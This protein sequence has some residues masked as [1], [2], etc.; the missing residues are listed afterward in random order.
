MQL[1]INTYPGQ[2]LTTP[3][4]LITDY[5]SLGQLGYI[6]PSSLAYVLGKDSTGDRRIQSLVTKHVLKKGRVVY[7]SA[8]ILKTIQERLHKNILTQMVE[9]LP[10]NALACIAAYRPKLSIPKILADERYHGAKYLVAIDIKKYF[11]NITRK[12]IIAALTSSG[13]DA[14]GATLIAR[15]STVKRTVR[16]K[17]VYTLQQGSNAS[18]AISNLVGYW[19]MDRY[20]LHVVDSLMATN[21][22]LRIEYLRY[23]D[24]LNFWMDGDLGIEHVR[25]VINSVN[26]IVRAGHFHIH[27]PE[28]MP[29]NHPKRNQRVL[30]IVLN[31]TPRI[32]KDDFM[33][34]RNTLFNCCIHSGFQEVWRYFQSTSLPTF[35]KGAQDEAILTTTIKTGLTPY[36]RMKITGSVNYVNQVNP[37][38]GK[39]LKKLLAAFNVLLGR[40]YAYTVQQVN[41]KRGLQLRE[42]VFT[43]L[44]TYRDDTETVDSFVEKVS[45]AT[46]VL[47]NK[48]SASADHMDTAGYYRLN[49]YNYTW[50]TSTSTVSSQ[51]FA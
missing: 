10:D 43:V 36:F 48:F 9:D 29:H 38:H 35:C 28:I 50:T 51:F 20:I 13:M 37:K 24:N 26:R 11:D 12:H 32:E 40:E 23:S 49:A 33:R 39:Q 2:Y 34:L 1:K 42:E 45:A 46:T 18:N 19:F 4:G 14:K 15:L 44:K 30:G 7:N 31:A 47:G 22:K 6:K 5:Y 17:T 8:P 41:G 3:W 27:K 21:P 16:G 25:T